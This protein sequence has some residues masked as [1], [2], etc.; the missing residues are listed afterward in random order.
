MTREEQ[1]S[2]YAIIVQSLHERTNELM[3]KVDWT[4]T[5]APLGA[6]HAINHKR[7]VEA[8]NVVAWILGQPTDYAHTWPQGTVLKSR[9]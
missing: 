7:L 3:A 9:T 6:L 2:A 5:P 4:Q 8:R 1:A